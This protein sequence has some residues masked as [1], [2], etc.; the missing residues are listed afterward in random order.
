MP[1]YITN[2]EARRIAQQVVREALASLTSDHPALSNLAWLD[3]GHTGAADAVAAFDGAGDPVTLELGVDIQEYS[4]ALGALGALTP[5]ADALP[6]F[7][8]ASS[9]GLAVLTSFARTL[10]DDASA[11]A[12]RTTLG[13][14]I[15]S[16]V[17]AYSTAL[18]AL[19]AL[20]P[21]ADRLPYFTG[22]GAAAIVP[23]SAFARTLIDDADAV[24]MRAT[25]GVVIGAD[26][27]AY[28]AGLA[29]LV[30]ADASAGLPYVS[31]ANTWT[32]LTLVADR[33]V[34]VN[35]SGALALETFSASRAT[36][37]LVKSR[38]DGSLWGWAAESP[39]RAHVATAVMGTSAM[40]FVN[41]SS[42]VTGSVAEGGI[43][44]SDG[45]FRYY[46]TSAATSG[47]AWLVEYT[48]TPFRPKAG[49]KCSIVLRMGATV[50]AM[51][52]WVGLNQTGGI[53]D[54]TAPSGSNHAA[55]LSLLTQDGDT[56][57]RLHTRDGSTTTTS[58]EFGPVIAAGNVY[59]IDFE[60]TTAA[61]LTVTVTDLDTGVSGSTTATST[62]P[63]NALHHIVNV[64]TKENVKKRMEIGAFE[65]IFPWGP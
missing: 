43:H 24:A 46:E 5:A 28:D 38:A 29:S 6:Y 53:G 51:R 64:V 7:S 27:Q 49:A 23:F 57:F 35:G 33:I 55:C 14:A 19:G 25:L 42:S 41:L 52:G 10:L 16:D 31:S 44:D 34:S 20:S 56:K 30:S 1:G 58:A 39:V 26:V 47:L 3:S 59:R 50:A 12:A 13:L 9:A 65:S 36:S 21:A 62:M 60:F 15:G 2:A 11:A 37:S 63:T 17:Q 8:G 22:A 61:S 32:S 48:H 18:A 40:G 45:S 4:A 54:V